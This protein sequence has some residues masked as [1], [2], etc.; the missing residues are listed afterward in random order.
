MTDKRVFLAVAI[1]LLVVGRVQGT[2]VR[3]GFDASSLDRNDDG[4]TGAVP[5][6]FSVNFFGNDHSNLYV[7]NNGNVTFNGPMW[8][9][10]PFGLTSAIGTPILATFFADVDTRAA[11]SDIVRFGSGTVDGRNAFGV[12]WIDVGYYNRH[13]DKLNSFQLVLIDR[14]DRHPGDFD[15][16]FNYD[17]ILWETGDASRGVNGF[18]GDCARVGYSSGSGLAGTYF[19]LPGSGLPGYFLDASPAALIHSS[20]NS[21][22]PGRYM[23][24]VIDGQP[25]VAPSPGALL[26]GGIGVSLIG[27]LR[28]RKVL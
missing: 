11:D 8:T 15:V 21:L 24:S 12:N 27:Y 26:L 14:S 4:S 6:G 18:G 22:I 16:E 2:A 7:N 28:R 5:I 1:A 9:Y 19:E 10:T 3:P 20:L 23:F 17:Q 13:A 25:C